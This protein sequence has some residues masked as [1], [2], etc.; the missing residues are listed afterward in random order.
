MSL[1]ELLEANARFVE[2]HE[3]QRLDDKP[4]RGIAVITCMDCRLT[5]F[6]EGALGLGRGDAVVLR[7][8]GNVVSDSDVVRSLAVAVYAQGVREVAVIG[9]RDCGMAKL[10]PADVLTAMSQVGVARG[11]VPGGD[12]RQWLKAF[13]S[14]EQNVREAVAA[15]RRSPLLPRDLAVY[16]LLVDEVTGRVSAVVG[17]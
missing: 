14:P 11:A 5:G 8:A 17:A 15:L 13:A 10:S 1:E 4:R 7:N 6:L 3:G 16:G 2:G 9:H 12:P